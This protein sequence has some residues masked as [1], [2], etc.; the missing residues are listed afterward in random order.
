[1]KKIGVFFLC[2]L[3]VGSLSA[4][5]V[6]TRPNAPTAV[7]GILDEAFT[8]PDDLSAIT[9]AE[10]LNE[11]DV[12]CVP[13]EQDGKVIGFEMRFLQSDKLDALFSDQDNMYYGVLAC[14]KQTV[15]VPMEQIRI[16]TDSETREFVITLLVPSGEKLTGRTCAVA[17]YTAARNDPIQNTLFCAN[18]ETTMP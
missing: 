4:C 12:T 18:K 17:F 1:M 15:G 14:G 13:L 6:L 11:A 3:C 9:A 5:G 2:M 8:L 16:L 7:S 10:T